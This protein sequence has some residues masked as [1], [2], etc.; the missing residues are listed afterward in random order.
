MEILSPLSKVRSLLSSSRVF[1][2]SIHRVSTGPSNSIHFWSGVSSLQTVLITLVRCAEHPR[3]FSTWLLDQA[4]L[5]EGIQQSL[6]CKY[7]VLP[8]MCPR[9]KAPIYFIVRKSQRIQYVHMNLFHGHGKF[10]PHIVQL[11]AAAARVIVP[12]QI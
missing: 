4:V 7:P 12:Q 9:I 11:N 2:D 10:Q 1:M 5:F 3:F 8:F 6:P